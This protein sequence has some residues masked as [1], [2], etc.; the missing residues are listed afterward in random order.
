[1]DRHAAGPRR[2]HL[3]I[4]WLGRDGRRRDLSYG[5]LAEATSRFANVLVRLGVAAGDP[6]FVLTG[7]IPE[8]YAAVLG[9]LKHRCPVTPL[10]ARSD[11]NPSARGSSSG[12]RGCW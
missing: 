4:R 1:V 8:L 7:R 3:A 9:A 5:A 11:R 10:F 12:V 6:V 2:D